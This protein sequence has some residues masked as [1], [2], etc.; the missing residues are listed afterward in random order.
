LDVADCLEIAA[1][2]E[3]L[4]NE[5]EFDAF[6]FKAIE[7][8]QL[9]VNVLGL[10]S[11][12]EIMNLEDSEKRVETFLL[13][14]ELLDTNNFREEFGNRLESLI[15]RAVEEGNKELVDKSIPV[16]CLNDKELPLE[17]YF[18]IG[19]FKAILDRNEYLS[20]RLIDL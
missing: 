6:Y 19:L 8:A 4:I 3:H 15:E 10:S 14:E 18:L 13:I 9:I 20:L 16:L 7:M 12:A 5:P 1:D 17:M 2:T 11:V